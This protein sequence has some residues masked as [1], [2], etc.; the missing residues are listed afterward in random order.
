VSYIVNDIKIELDQ[1]LSAIAFVQELLK[2]NL[3]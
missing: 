2:P 1:S 3:V